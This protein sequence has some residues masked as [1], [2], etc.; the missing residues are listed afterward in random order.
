MDTTESV[1][2][3]VWSEQSPQRKSSKRKKN[4]EKIEILEKIL[5]NWQENTIKLDELDDQMRSS[6]DS[7]SRSIRSMRDESKI[8]SE[9]NSQFKRQITFL[10]NKIATAVSTEIDMTKAIN[11]IKERITWATLALAFWVAFVIMTISFTKR[12]ANYTAKNTESTPSTN[13][14]EHADRN[15][16]TPQPASVLKDLSGKKKATKSK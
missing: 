6:F 15:D 1:I 2:S 5:A 9:Q 8:I 13:K 3:N 14:A 11:K 7:L 12:A 10:D 4:D 16:I